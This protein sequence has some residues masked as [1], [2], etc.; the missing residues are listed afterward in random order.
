[1]RR[2]PPTSATPS[3]PTPSTPSPSTATNY[4]TRE[5]LS[6]WVVSPVFTWNTG[7]NFK[8]AGGTDTVNNQDSGVV[9]NGVDTHTLQKKAVGYYRQNGSTSNPLLLLNPAL[10]NLSNPSAAAVSSPSTPGQFGQFVYLTSPQFVNTDFAVTKNFPVWEKGAPEHSGRND[11]RLQP[12]QLRSRDFG[13]PI[14]PPRLRPSLRL[15]QPG[16]ISTLGTAYPTAAPAPSS[17]A[18]TFPSDLRLAP[19]NPASWP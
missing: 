16:G 19:I 11:Q 5:T 6:G 12:P 1:M 14:A 7:R 4:L 17:S 9:L 15:P 18:Q 13:G 8:L 10:F 2:R 3:K